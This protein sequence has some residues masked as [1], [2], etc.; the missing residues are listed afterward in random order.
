[1]WQSWSSRSGD[2]GYLQEVLRYPRRFQAVGLVDSGAASLP[3]TISALIRSSIS[4]IRGWPRMNGNPAPGWKEA[5]SSLSRYPNISVGIS[6]VYDYS[7]QASPHEDTWPW[8]EFLLQKLGP[9]H[10]PL[11][12]DTDRYCDYSAVFFD[13]AFGVSSAR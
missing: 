6:A 10:F 3:T 5:V 1:M 4:G 8:I 13:D 2:D 11:L 12:L 7:Q 9:E